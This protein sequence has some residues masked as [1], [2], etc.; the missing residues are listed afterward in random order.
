MQNK[1]LIRFFAIAFALVCLYQLSFTFFSQRVERDAKAFSRSERVQAIAWDLSGGDELF[2]M[3]LMDSLARE[4]ERYYLDSM[5]NEVV[6]NLGIRRYTFQDVKERE[7]NL[8]LDLRGGMNV[9]LEISVPEIIRALS[10]NSQDP[11]FLLAMENAIEAQRGSRE[12]FVVLFGRAFREAD[13][14]ASLAAIFATPEMRDRISFNSTNEEVLRVLT[15][16][17][18]S[19]IDRSFQILRTRIDR[20]G[21]AQPNI[22]RLQTSGRILVELPGIKEQDRV[23]RLLQGT[24]RLE[25]WETFDY[26]E[27]YPF[28]AEANERLR[29]T[30]PRPAE[31]AEELLDV[32]E[33]NQQTE[34]DDLD[35]LMAEEVVDEDDLLELLTTDPEEDITFDE[36]VV[37]ANPLFSVLRPNIVSDPG[38]GEF[39]LGGGPIVG[40]AAI[41]DTARVSNML[42]QPN[43]RALFPREMRLLWTVKPERQ[44]ENVLQLIA[45]RVP[46]RGEPPLTGDVIVDARQDFDPR[47][48]A[49]EISMTMNTEGAREWR[50]LTAANIGKSIAIVLD[51]YVY[52]FP[53]VQ[54]EISGG[55]SSI[56]GQ[57]SVAEAQDL[58]NI[59]RAGS[60]PAPA[61]IVEE[62]IVGPS[63]GREAISSGLTSFLIAFIIVL[64]YMTIYYSRAGFV[65]DLALV[66]NIFFIFGVLAS[67]GAVLTL[68]GIAGIVLTLGMAVDA[69]VII[70]ERILE[71]IRA[72]KGQKLAIADGYKNAY[73]AIIDGNVTTLLTGVV[74]YIFG[75]GPV[76]G[77]AT[78]LIIGI[79]SSLFTAIFLSRLIFSYWI[80]RNVAISFDTKISKDVLTKVN[81]DFIGVRKKFYTISSIVIFVG[82]ISLIVRGLS[83]GVDFSGGRSYVVR[84]DQDINTVEM[85][86]AL[87]E[88]FGEAPEVKTFGP[89]NQVKITTSFLIDDE[90]TT[91]DSIAERRLFDGIQEFFVNPMTFE[92]FVS[93]DDDRIIGRMSSQKVGPSVAAD[94]QRGAVIA[95]SIALIIIFIY[96]AIRF[97]KWQYGVGGLV[98]LFHDSLIVISLYS[99]LYNVVPWTMEIDQTFIAAI[100]TIIGYSV[101]DTVIIFDRIRENKT[102]YPKR[103]MKTNINNALNATLSRTF[104]TSGTTIAVLM[105]I[106][107]FGGE[108]IRGFAFALMVGIAVGTYSSLFNATPIAYDL[109]MRQQ[110]KVAKNK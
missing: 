95:V 1:G 71:E 53:T 70:Y 87:M 16:E 37:R 23:R 28:F 109:L 48:G 64:I 103:D 19:A 18:N 46:T 15:R 63:L 85:R 74:L 10:G 44:Q 66:T 99:L 38:T 108:V 54:A 41:A 98:T 77:F 55:R 27:L 78:T 26:S 6:F 75:T 80:D 62:A 45:I 91:A 31:V 4:Y 100:L 29:E 43:I 79:L 82:I 92:Q 7:L 76:Q 93:D 90:S 56:T 47:T 13:P 32:P 35:D 25:F 14:N 61:R 33:E 110:R 104:N 97:K 52:S 24:A 86:A 39:F 84:F 102:L 2:E 81:F 96:V 67:L 40:T 8:G 72:G 49:A 88:E 69:N 3:V 60:L 17:V 34:A 89:S 22:Q 36:D 21:V 68:P 9:T 101:N 12:D 20:F 59:L 107:L 51:D 94:I 42:R 105:I 57:F 73:S 11:T 5:R 58:A 65:S 50:R 83:L 30:T 106:F